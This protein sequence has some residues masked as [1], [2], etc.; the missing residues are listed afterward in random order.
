MIVLVPGDKIPADARLI[1]TSSLK[2]NESS[3]TGEWLAVDKI[4]K[5][6]TEGVS[7]ADRKN[8]VYMGVFNF[9]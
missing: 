8:M 5:T 9:H 3:L 4:E 1:E 7:L 2:I 6:L